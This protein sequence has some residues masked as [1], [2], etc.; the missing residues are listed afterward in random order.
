MNQ[1]NLAKLKE[2]FEVVSAEHAEALKKSQENEA[3]IKELQEKLEIIKAE[4]ATNT[5]I[6]EYEELF[7]AVEKYQAALGKSI[8]KVQLC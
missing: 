7:Q 3:S 8:S 6:K 4:T 5:L 2:T 1:E